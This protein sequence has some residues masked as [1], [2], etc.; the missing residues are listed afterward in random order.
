MDGENKEKDTQIIRAE[1]I[2]DNQD[3]GEFDDTDE[4]NFDMC[5]QITAP[6][7]VNYILG[8]GKKIVLS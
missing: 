2:L 8:M 5:G 3:D 7:V 4:D 1:A 6:E